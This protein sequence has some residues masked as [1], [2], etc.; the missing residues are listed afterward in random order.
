[1]KIFRKNGNASENFQ[2]STKILFMEKQAEEITPTIK[3]TKKTSIDV[4]SGKIKKKP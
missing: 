4:F 3:K 2:L 1:M